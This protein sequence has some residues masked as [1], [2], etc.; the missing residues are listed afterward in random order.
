MANSKVKVVLTPDKEVVLASDNPNIGELVK[1]IVDLRD[2]LDVEHIDV[3][4]EAEGFDT[5]S[6]AEV[7]RDSAQQ[8]LDAI[9]LEKGAFDKAM[10]ALEKPN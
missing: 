7:I 3:T 9:E 5:K 6:F 4:C 8:F 1:A 10:V 2:T